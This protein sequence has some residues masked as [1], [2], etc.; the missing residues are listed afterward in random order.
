M[1]RPLPTDSAPYTHNYI[2]LVNGDSAAEAVKNHAGEILTFYT[3][4]PDDKAQFAYGKG[5]WTL[6]EVL[7]HVIDA[8]R[9]FS[10]RAMRIARKDATPLPGFDENSY[11]VNSQ[12][13]NRSFASLK[14]EF[15]L[16][17]RATDI[18]IS[19]LNEEQLQNTGFASNS[20]VTA[21]AVA[22]IVYGHL[23]HHIDIIKERYFKG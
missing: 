1:P 11:T 10:Y 12:A 20:P 15:A 9:V 23:L 17:R 21:N 8:E 22:F 16:L 4:L 19:T 13:C 14:D 3:G 2:S 7:Q 18:F 6:Q 5:K